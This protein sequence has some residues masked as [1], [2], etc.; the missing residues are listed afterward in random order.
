MTSRAIR[1]LT[2]AALSEM[3]GD[4][5]ALYSRTGRLGSASEKLLQELLLQAFHSIR[6]DRQLM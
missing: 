6:S 2:N 3:S 5:E 4:F 1:D